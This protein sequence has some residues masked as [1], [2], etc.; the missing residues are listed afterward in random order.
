[1]DG[2][3]ALAI[4]ILGR[5]MQD[6]GGKSLYMQAMVRTKWVKGTR[7]TREEI[8]ADAE[9]WLRDSDQCDLILGSLGH[10]WTV[11]EGEDY[12]ALAKDQDFNWTVFAHRLSSLV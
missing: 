11:Y 4:R 3:R 9:A 8:A 12:A 7:M 6:V 5:A 2:W 10:P 1:M